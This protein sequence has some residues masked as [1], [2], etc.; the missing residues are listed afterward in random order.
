[1]VNM[2]KNKLQI[3]RLRM[4]FK[5]AKEFAEYLNIKHSTYISMENN[6]RQMSLEVLYDISKKLNIPMEDILYKE[7]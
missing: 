4:G 5:T 7:E 1:M 2:I 3:I 6:T